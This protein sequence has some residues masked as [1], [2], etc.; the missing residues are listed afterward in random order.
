MFCCTV[1]KVKNWIQITKHFEKEDVELHVFTSLF[2]D[3]EDQL[4]KLVNELNEE[5]K[6]NEADVPE[7]EYPIDRCDAILEKLK[8][9][10]TCYEI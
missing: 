5:A 3:G 10:Y 4:Q 9:N 2:E 7:K 1:S 6:Q 8:N